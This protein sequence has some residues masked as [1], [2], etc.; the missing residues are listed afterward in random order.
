M[1]FSDLPLRW[2]I[3]ALV[4]FFGSILIINWIARI[5]VPTLPLA[6]TAVLLFTF[7]GFA[8]GYLIGE[9]QTTKEYTKRGMTLPLPGDAPLDIEHDGQRAPRSS[10]Q[11]RIR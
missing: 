3:T 11:K 1:R 2:K 10:S 7:V 5:I 9:R 6:L 4:A 8:I